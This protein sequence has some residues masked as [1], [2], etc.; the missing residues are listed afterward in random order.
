[1]HKNAWIKAADNLEKILT[2]IVAVIMILLSIIVSYQVF[3]RYVLRDSPF[4]VEE[5]SEVM[6]MWLGILGSAAAT[7]TESHMDLQIVV[8]RLPEQVRMW[9]RTF[10][11]LLIAIFAFLIFLF[12]IT[13]VKNLMTGTLLFLPIPIGYTYTILPVSGIIIILFSV[14][15]GINRVVKFYT[16]DKRGTK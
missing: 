16:K 5:G 8:S 9:L 10:V 7:W 2:A 6:M 13:L 11:D 3:A 15:K 12:S 14:I 4:W 1:M